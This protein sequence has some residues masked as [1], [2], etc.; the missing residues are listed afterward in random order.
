M[1]HSP[2]TCN[3]C[4]GARICLSGFVMDVE[5]CHLISDR[6]SIVLGSDLRCDLTVVDPLVPARALRLRH[7]KRHTGPKQACDAHWEVEAN[8]GV[9]FCLNGE[10]TQRARLRFGDELAIGCHRLIF[11]EYSDPARNRRGNVSVDDLCR[12]LIATRN[13]P[14]AFLAGCP[15]HL[16][17]RRTRTALK[18][19][20]VLAAV[21]L[22]LLLVVPQEPTFQ[23]VQPPM[24]VVMLAEVAQTP[25]PADVRSLREVERRQ[26][27]APADEREVSDLEAPPDEIAPDPLEPLAQNTSAPRSAPTMPD[28]LTRDE[29]PALAPIEPAVT[30]A[31]LAFDRQPQR[32]ETSA[33]RRRLTPTE[34]ENPRV[35][36]ELGRV[37]VEIEQVP[38]ATTGAVQHAPQ[39]ARTAEAPRAEDLAPTAQEQAQMLDAMRPSPLDF[40]MH[41]GTR[42]PVAR[43]AETL[44]P[45]AIVEDADEGFELDGVVSEAEM[46]ASWKSGQFRLHGPGDPPPHADPPTQCYVSRVEKDGREY[47]YVAFVNTD[48]NLSQLQLNRQHIWHDDSIEIFL[49]TNFNRRDYYHMIVN[50][51][52]RFHA[53]HV[54]TPEHGIN[55][56]GSPW[57]VN[58]QI[59]TTINREAGQWTAEIL[60]PFDQL[61]GAPA[62]G[63][64]W[65]VNFTRSFRGQ[66]HPNHVYQNW[67]LVY[68]GQTTNYHNPQLYGVFQW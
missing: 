38:T 10:L 44:E 36:R 34:A 57:R 43:M 2:A 16:D 39:L 53:R 52:G 66:Q 22:L 15:S 7:I 50:A 28:E 3:Q 29:A 63:T 37:N 48:P 26:I 58:P 41:R 18:V 45:M 49:D 61:G 6:E 42:I 59:K 46:A 9:R 19:G 51:Q 13:V 31:S 54:P 25:S 32:L 8:R 64:R 11:S 60:I 47:L 62:E 24:E 55:N 1:T 68:D 21:L 23:P 20:G 14:A 12:H 30:T 5:A 17:R 35:Q 27:E 4:A 56:A 67:F 33:P 40:E 65:A